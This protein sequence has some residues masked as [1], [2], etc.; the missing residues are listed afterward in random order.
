[1]QEKSVVELNGRKVGRMIVET[2]V[3]GLDSLQLQY[4]IIEHNTF[5]VIAFTGV[6]GHFDAQPPLFEQSMQ[7]FEI[8][9]QAGK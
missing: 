1:V 4:Y 3:G 5:Y 2:K 7:T 9:A 8:V 6:P